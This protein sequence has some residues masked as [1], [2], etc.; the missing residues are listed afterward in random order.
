MENL[1]QGGAQKNIGKDDVESYNITVPSNIEEQKK[2]AECLSKY[3]ELIS[4]SEQKLELY[5]K[6]KKAMLQKMFC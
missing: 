3:D 1:G 4:A 5:K 6:L 2:I